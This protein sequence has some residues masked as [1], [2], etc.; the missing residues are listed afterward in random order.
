MHNVKNGYERI[1]ACAGSGKT[2]LMADRVTY[3]VKECGIEP[4]RIVVFSFT[5]VAASEARQRLLAAGIEGVRVTTMHSFCGFAVAGLQVCGV[6]LGVSFASSK[7][8]VI[9]DVVRACQHPE[10]FEALTSDFDYLCVDEA[11]DNDPQQHALCQL[12]LQRVPLAGAMAVGDP[13]QSIYGF[14][15]ADPALFERFFHGLRPATER[16]MSIN[17]RCP[18]GVVAAANALTRRLALMRRLSLRSA[19]LDEQP[20]SVLDAVVTDHVPMRSIMRPC[21]VECHPETCPECEDLRRRTAP[22]ITAHGSRTKEVAYVAQ[23]IKRLTDRGVRTGNIAILHRTNDNLTAYFALISIYGIN[24]VLTTEG[25]GDEGNHVALST[26]HGSKGG[27]WE[28]VFL[29]GASDHFFPLIHTQDYVPDLLELELQE[30]RLLYVA[31]TRTKRELQI[32]FVSTKASRLTR[33]IGRR[34]LAFFRHKLS[35]NCLAV[36]EDGPDN[37][38]EESDET[39]VDPEHV[40]L[41]VAEIVRSR[42]ELTVSNWQAEPQA[43]EAG[44]SSLHDLLA[45]PGCVALGC[46]EQRL[47]HP[48]CIARF[49]A[50]GFHGEFIESLVCAYLSVERGEAPLLGPRVV[51]QLL[52]PAIGAASLRAL[53]AADSPEL[54][55]VMLRIDLM[56]RYARA[57]QALPNGA[58]RPAVVREGLVLANIPPTAALVDALCDYA[59][60]IVRLYR[61][62]TGHEQL[63]GMVGVERGHEWTRRMTAL[64]GGAPPLSELAHGFGTWETAYASPRVA[65]EVRAARRMVVGMVSRPPAL[66]TDEATLRRFVVAVMFPVAAANPT[67]VHRMAAPPGAEGAFHPIRTYL[68]EGD[69][70]ELVRDVVAQCAVLARYLADRLL[71]VQ[72]TLGRKVDGAL[73]FEVHGSADLL[74]GDMLIEIKAKNSQADEPPPDVWA[75]LC[76][77]AAI[78]KPRR[79]AY[80]DVFQRTLYTADLSGWR[81]GDAFLAEMAEQKISDHPRSHGRLAKRS[82]KRSR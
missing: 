40:R 19:S 7:A 29:V 8:S 27:E 12:L 9:S 61:D 34:E 15:G 31:L 55:R 79:V 25:G 22:L 77:Y 80:L 41:G 65:F 82:Q 72:P 4:R 3:L 75:Q 57:W 67:I 30:L 71:T 24:V 18:W 52:A 44:G 58:S 21:G 2:K 76:A 14:C 1:S 64:C 59:V 36:A 78:A 60:A 11:Q 23:A 6:N 46:G 63:T 54:R 62:A 26:V 43:A 35:A 37:A 68:N 42:G 70:R 5:L 39:P 38:V 28:Y 47:K 50:A 32:T 13:N 17:W 66:P 51:R 81:G 73:P 10:A 56:D 49:N 48:E 33:F 74:A 69:S 53:V 20:D 45:S 16:E